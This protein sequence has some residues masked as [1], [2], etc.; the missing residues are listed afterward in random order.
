MLEVMNSPPVKKHQGVFPMLVTPFDSSG[1]VSFEEL[2][3]IAQHQLAAGVA[4]LSLLGLAGEAAVLTPAERMSIAGHILSITK[5]VPV[6]V[7]CTAPET[8]TATELALHAADNG[9]A[10]VM[11]APPSKADWS[12][13]QQFEHYARVA[14]AIAPTPLMVQDAPAF[15]GVSLSAEFITR[16]AQSCPNVTY[17]KPESMP[18]ADAVAKLAT[19]PAMGIFGGHGGLYFLEVLEAGAHGL[20]PDCAQPQLFQQIFASWT[21]GD[22]DSAR[23]AFY[24]LLPLLVWQFQSLD[25]FI[26]AVK[27][28][29]H[30][31]GLLKHPALRE[32]PWPIESTSRDILLRHARRAGAL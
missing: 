22:R 18:A 15:V 21:R 12:I 19:L 5:G 29:L 23:Q 16:L 2:A 7:G 20:I 11:V 32:R 26:A 27:I 4:G 25:C 10:V 14:E 28:L 8:T 6:I 3:H 17:A 1:R 30:E 13:A 24:Q 31:K 9:A